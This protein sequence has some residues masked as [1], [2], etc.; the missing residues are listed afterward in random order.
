M[1]HIDNYNNNNI[2]I[3]LL[4]LTMSLTG[5][6][7]LFD[8]LYDEPT[9]K[10]SGVEALGD[11]ISG[12]LYIEANAWDEWFYVDLHAIRAAVTAAHDGGTMDTAC[13]RFEPYKVPT[14]LTGAWDGKTRIYTYLFRVLTGNGLDDNELL[15]VSETDAQ[16]APEHW[17]FAIHRNNNRTNGGSALETGYTSMSQLPASS[18]ALLGE[19]AASGRDT[20]FTADAYTQQAVWVDQSTMLQEVIPCQGI[21]VNEVLSRWIEMELPPMPPTFKHNGHV[22]L[23]RMSDGTTAALRCKNYISARNVKCCL[24]IEYLYPY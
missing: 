20:A 11:T 16:P 4:W 2:I 19:M 15:A 10:G 5:C 3:L 17:D 7:G 13:L 14:A 23:L 9:E 24:T 1:R 12:T 21:A 22:F 6:E 8:G 18:T